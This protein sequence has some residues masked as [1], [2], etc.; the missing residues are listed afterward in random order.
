MHN[1]G[2]SIMQ[3]A[4]SLHVD[5]HQLSLKLSQLGVREQIEPKNKKQKFVE[6][7]ETRKVT[8]DY[9][10]GMS[11]KEI[12]NSLGRSTNYICRI[13]NHYDMVETDRLTTV[14]HMTWRPFGQVRTEKQ[15]YWLGF[16]MADGSVSSEANRYEVEFGLAKKDEERVLAFADF[17]HTKPSLHIQE[18][19]V[20]TEKNPEGLL[21]VRVTISDVQMV[22]DLAKYGCTVRK[23][24]TK[25]FP[26]MLPQRLWRHFIRGYFDGNGYVTQSSGQCAFGFVSSYDMC[27]AFED[28]LLEENIINRRC[29]F[30]S[31]GKASVFCRGGNLQAKKFFDYLY[32]RATT[33]MTRKYDVFNAILGQRQ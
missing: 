16:L 9:Q 6:T 20:K 24:L 15:A 18:R 25:K 30:G 4:K 28:I 27:K 8:F 19:L 2:L 17:I 1:D 31:S 29:K 12:A 13:L 14:Y 23:S 7:E 10:N 21:Q 33:Y 3:I 5:R 11:I 26:Y 32:K 22:K